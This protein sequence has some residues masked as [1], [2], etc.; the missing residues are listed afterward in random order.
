MTESQLAII[1]EILGYL[2]LFT[3][4]VSMQTKKMAY[5]VIWQ[6]MSNVFVVTQFM[7][8]G[9]FSAM[10]VCV[11]GAVETLIIFLFDR[12]EKKFPIYL[13]VVFTLLS[14]TVA[15]VVVFMKGSFDLVSDSIPMLASVLFNIAMA[16]TRSSVARIL[17]MLNS[18]L[19]LLLNVINFN[20]SLAITY[21]ILVAMTIV[22]IIRLDRKEWKS[23]FAKILKKTKNNA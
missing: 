11:I 22:G 10:G 18:S 15:S 3:A 21:S 20:L 19:W 8:R 13:T 5:L 23:F 6:C 17:M 1:I 2:V 16:T 7:L 4:L 14:I 12:K 9:E